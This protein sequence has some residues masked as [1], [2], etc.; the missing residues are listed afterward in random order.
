M[1]D[2]LLSIDDVTLG[3]WAGQLLVCSDGYKLVERPGQRP[4]RESEIE[5]WLVPAGDMAQGRLVM[6]HRK[7]RMLHRQFARLSQRRQAR[8]PEPILS[9]A[10]KWGLLEDACPN[11]ARRTSFPQQSLDEEA[12]VLG[13][14][15]SDWY[16]RA[17]HVAAWVAWWD[18]LATEPQRLARHFTWDEESGSL[19]YFFS[20]DG[21][22][23]STDQADPK[24]R[25]RTRLLAGQG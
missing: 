5:S 21:R 15:L 13:E 22:S 24:C 9:F 6:H 11:P 14:R 20:Y 10:G 25:Y 18:V 7:P 17:N 12:I 19:R 23:L 4:G 16:L 3:D 1:D 2:D 8:K